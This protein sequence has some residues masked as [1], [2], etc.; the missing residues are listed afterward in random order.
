MNTTNGTGTGFEGLMGPNL[1]PNTLAG[2]LLLVTL[3]ICIRASYLYVQTRSPRLFVL[4]L[5]MGIIALTSADNFIANIITISFNTYWFLYIGQIV[6]YLFIMLSLMQGSDLYLRKLVRWHVW[7]SVAVVGLLVLAPLSP[8]FPNLVT[9]A[10]LSVFR[11]VVAL[12]IFFCY[13]Y[14]FMKKETRFSFLMGSAFLLVAFGTFV[15]FEKYFSTSPDLLD[16]VGDVTRITGLVILL[17]AV[18][19]G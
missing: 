9:R 6:S 1:I 5:S 19:L 16:N 11:G 8:A 7:A 13:S 15:S 3:L 17:V 18:I 2:L 14:A 12:G 10:G 4:G